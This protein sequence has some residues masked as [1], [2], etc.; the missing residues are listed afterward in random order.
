MQTFSDSNLTL[1]GRESIIGGSLLIKVDEDIVVCST[2][3]YPS[4][5]TQIRWAPF[6]ANDI[7]TGNVFLWQHTNQSVASIL[8]NVTTTLL[9]PVAWSILSAEGNGTVYNLTTVEGVACSRDNWTQ[10]AVGDLSGRNGD[11]SI[12]SDGVLR[13]FL[14]DPGLPLDMVGG[15]PL[16]LSSG[17]RSVG[18]VIRDYFPL[19]AVAEVTEVGGRVKFTQRSP[20]EATLVSVTGLEG[21]QYA[22]HTFPP[23]A[24]CTNTGGTFDPRTVGNTPEGDTLDSYQFGNL[25]GKFGSS[26]TYSD[27]YLPLSG[28]D[29]VIGRALVVT[30][31][32]V[33]SGC[34]LI[35]HA[36]DVVEMKATLSVPGFSGTITFTQPARDP[37]ADTVITIETDI[38][39]EVDVFT[40]TPSSPVSTS[41]TP[42]P[43]S[44]V[45]L[46]P[47]QSAAGT[48]VTSSSPL[49]TP[50][51]MGTSFPSIL[52]PFPTPSLTS[53]SFLFLPTSVS[54]LLLPSPTVLEPDSSGD[55]ESALLPLETTVNVMGG[56]RRRRREASAAKFR[57]SLRRLDGS[58]PP[59]DCSQ[60]DLIGER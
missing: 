51:P 37:F 4:L 10:C 25:S 43:S 23:T 39:V 54:F 19:E 27:P 12:D 13:Q 2:I 50:V 38:T 20:L 9:P 44:P 30:R 57:W 58:T 5:E 29:S 60:L 55:R 8:V 11:L 41:F 59:D 15:W 40:S 33:V 31:E 16:A 42:A 6:R 28:R 36:G 22:V 24:N 7:A 34:G 45:Y 47:S 53:S 56:G 14:T 1:F 32:G 21:M 48:S 17:E 3:G 46:T 26:Q 18:A 52:I 49:A 35:R